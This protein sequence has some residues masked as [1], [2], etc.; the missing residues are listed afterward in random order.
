[1]M[2]VESTS[3][4]SSG[5]LAKVL[6]LCSACAVDDENEEWGGGVLESVTYG[7]SQLG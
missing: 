5:R 7:L 3:R 6:E 1:M 4:L 2:G